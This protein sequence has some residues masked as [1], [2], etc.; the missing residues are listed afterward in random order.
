MAKVGRPLG[1]VVGGAVAVGGG[2]AG[3]GVPVGVD[4]AGEPRRLRWTLGGR[5]KGEACGTGDEVGDFA[6]D[7]G[8]GAVD[9]DTHACASKTEASRDE[10]TGVRVEP[11]TTAEKKK[12]KKG[13]VA[14]RVELKVNR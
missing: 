7:V 9:T 6:T 4:V 13:G 11:R 2:V 12:K 5:S 1:L 8:L 3:A 14:R 10:R